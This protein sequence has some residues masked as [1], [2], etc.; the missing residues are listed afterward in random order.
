[1]TARWGARRLDDLLD[2]AAAAHPG[3]PAVC[4]GDRIITYA[5]LDKSV[6]ALA[7]DLAGAGVRPG[8]RVGILVERSLP[9]VT[10][11]YAVLRIGAVAAPLDVTDPPERT[12]RMARNAG[13]R[14]VVTRIDAA[15]AVAG[16]LDAERRP[17]QTLDVLS[18]G[19]RPPSE[20]DGGYLLF[21]SGSTGTP[22]GVLLSHENV[23]YFVEWAV[24]EFGV[25][26]ADRIG[27]QAAFTFDLST[28]DIF[29]SALAGACLCLMPEQHKAFPRDTVEWLADERI[30]VF[31]AV[32]TLWM[33]A[34][35]RG[36]IANRRPDHLR[37][38][39][40][41]GEPFPPAGLRRYL[42][43]FP[44]RAFYNLYGP[45]E[46]NV[47]TVERITP[48]WSPSAGLSIGVPL[49]GTR[50]TLVDGEIAVAG[51]SVL[52]G[53]LQDGAIQDPTVRVEFA[54]GTSE[55]AYLTGDLA[56]YGPD[57]RLYLSGRRD[58]QI[59][60]R[61]HRIE[62][63]AIEDVAHEV[64]GVR[65]CAAVC[66]PDVY[67]HGEIWLFAVTDGTRAEDISR[68]LAAVLPAATLPDRVEIVDALPLN[69]RGKIDRG[70]LRSRSYEL[71]A[72]R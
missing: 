63:P 53:Y 13:L 52:R 43:L 22:K 72:V 49:P 19:G 37:I 54:D 17:G 10:A 62:L 44:D 71:G 29:G 32:P 65:A 8:D 59:K 30:S 3:R 66:R 7:A 46:T 11:V 14:F 4:D 47:C 42:D 24:E 27:S 41:A 21:T 64:P 1:M 25:R 38:I 36:G 69:G 60:R 45:T 58:Q 16:R 51:P 2:Q 55:R 12:A 48:D 67:A 5:G 20:G 70:A 34:L 56:R 9:A 31:Y 40:F 15:D 33:A 6:T 39:A 68:Q 26:P 23:R 35:D 18:I 50:I 28:F 57:G 61:G